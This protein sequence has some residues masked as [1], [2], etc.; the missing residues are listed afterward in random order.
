MR[1]RYVFAMY[2]LVVRLKVPC[3]NAG[4]P[5]LALAGLG[6]LGDCLVGGLASKLCHTWY[7]MH[8]VASCP[9]CVQG[10]T[11]RVTLKTGAVLEGL[12]HTS[13]VQGDEG[14]GMVL[15]MARVVVRDAHAT[16]CECV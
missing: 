7:C 2:S 14:L 1:D 5:W 3:P 11:V 16:C 13:S 12:F 6:W 9:C 4:W 8:C 15:N 10:Q